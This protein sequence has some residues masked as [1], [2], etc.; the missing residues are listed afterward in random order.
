MAGI[1]AAVSKSEGGRNTGDFSWILRM[2]HLYLSHYLIDLPCVNL[3][4]I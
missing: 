1:I 3:S 2:V 4:L